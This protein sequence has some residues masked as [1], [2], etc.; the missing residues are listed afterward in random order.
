[1]EKEDKI[2]IIVKSICLVVLGLLI[3]YVYLKSR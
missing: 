1:M 2:K 3:G